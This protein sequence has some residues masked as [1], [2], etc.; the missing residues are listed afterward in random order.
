MQAAAENGDIYSNFWI[1]RAYH[2]GNGLPDGNKIDFGKAIKHYL[3]INEEIS[4]FDI[5]FYSILGKLGHQKDKPQ[6]ILWLSKLRTV[7]YY[8]IIFKGEK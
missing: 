8:L 7:S 5:P 2:T 1:A 6:W 4:S 3:N